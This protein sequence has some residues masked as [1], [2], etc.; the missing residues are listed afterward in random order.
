[1]SMVMEKRGVDK[2]TVK[3]YEMWL[4]DLGPAIGSKQGGTRPVLIVSND[5]GN[6]YAPIVIGIP[7]TT[8][9]KK[10]IP[11]HVY[12]QTVGCEI[13]DNSILMCEQITTLDKEKNLLY[14]L[15]D[16]PKSYVHQVTQ[17][18]GVSLA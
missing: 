4:A 8:K 17:A 10:P 1:M 18:I 6:K 11:T 12:L 14:K 3:K 2:K 7:T 5:V 13:A 15:F 16:L 9:R